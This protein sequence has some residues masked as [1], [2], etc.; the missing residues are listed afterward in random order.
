MDKFTNST[1]FVDILMIILLIIIILKLFNIINWSWVIVLF[2]I[3]FIPAIM[4]FIV[5]FVL[6]LGFGVMVIWILA[7]K[8]ID[9]L[10]KD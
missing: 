2:P 3:W 1:K 10:S 5:L 4:I 8:I 6:L 7:I 9:F